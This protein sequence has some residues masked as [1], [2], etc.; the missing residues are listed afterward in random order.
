MI[1][2]IYRCETGN[3]FSCGHSENPFPVS[4]RILG[5]EIIRRDDEGPTFTKDRLVSIEDKAL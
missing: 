2:C 4:Q 5:K 3:G 1:E